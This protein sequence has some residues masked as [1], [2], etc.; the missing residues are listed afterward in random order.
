[1]VYV[2]PGPQYCFLTVG[3][4]GLFGVCC[5]GAFGLFRCMGCAV[6]VQSGYGRVVIDDE[7]R[8]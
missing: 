6:S 7:G 1:M 5:F 4:F 8:R 2:V 3:A